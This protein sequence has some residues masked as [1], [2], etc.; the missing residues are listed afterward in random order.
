MKSLV[1]RLGLMLMG[2]G[3]FACIPTM[4]T[5]PKPGLTGL[6][7]NRTIVWKDYLGVNAHF[8]WFPP[9]AYAK[10]M[11]QLNALGLNM[12]RVD[13]H[14]D[15]H[16][17]AEGQ[18]KLDMVDTL[19]K[20]MDKKKVRSLMYLVGSAPHITSAPATAPN[21]DQY[22][23]RDPEVYAKRLT[24]LALRYPQ[25]E[26]W[27][28][29][30]EPNLPA[31]WAP[32]EDPDKYF[33]LLKASVMHLRQAVPNKTIVMAGMAYYSQ[34]P[35]RNKDLMLEKL[36]I[37]GA[38]NSGVVVA[39]HPYSEFP[40][41]DVQADQDFI[42]RAQIMNSRLRQAGVKQIWAT[43]WGWSSY[44]G[45]KE[46]Q[47]LIG[48][49]GQADFVLRRLALMT[50]RDYDRTYLFA[51]S[52]LDGRAGARDQKYGL[53][54]L[55]G[56]PKPAYLGLQRFLNI[57]G[58]SIQSS[59]VPEFQQPLAQRVYAVAWKRPDQ[60]NLLAL[61]SSQAM[62]TKI[63]LNKPATLHQ[64]LAGTKTSLKPDADGWVQVPV[65]TQFQLL[66][67]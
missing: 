63:K 47:A 11:D 60:S 51:L 32:K 13:L 39:Y 15:R 38:L 46:M 40:E 55:K 26:S 67:W 64:P 8:L 31:F 62:S 1:S 33:Q 65:K 29:W 2:L 61:W 6:T 57:T 20:E 3:L 42:E 54:D 58:P 52:D 45:P 66:D 9:A 34:M 19:V 12:V 44:S 25:V 53:L 30:N 5:A 27:Q 18:L 28:V 24:Q 4:A 56:A 59:T 23:P 50:T 41:G 49:D 37:M 43:E 48:E 36:G 21:K 14:W 10:Q 16:E 22:P 35:T 17:P 7:P